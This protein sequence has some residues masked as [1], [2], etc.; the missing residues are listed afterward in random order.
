MD[1]ME[2]R[3]KNLMAALPQDIDVALIQSDINRRYLTGLD[4]SAG[5]LLCFRDEAVLLIDFRYIEIARETVKHC[6]VVEQDRVYAQIVSLFAEHGV[7]NVAIESMQVTLHE[8]SQLKKNITGDWNW[9]CDDTLSRT[10]TEMRMVKSEDEIEKLRKAEQ[11]TELALADIKT[12]A[13]VGMSEREIMLRLNQTMLELGSEGES[14]PTIALVGAATSMPHGVPSAQ[15]YLKDGDFVLLDF[16]AIFEGYHSDTTRTFCVGD[17]SAKMRAVYDIVLK[18]QE[19]ALA[20]ARS[21]ITG[22]Q[23]D[24]AARK[25]I[26]D[27]GYGDAFGHSL[28]HGV[29]LEIHEQPNASPRSNV[30]LKQGHVVTIEPGIYLAGEFGVRTE[31]MI[32]IR[33]GGYENLTASSK[34][35]KV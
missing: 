9:T 35:I 25:V 2:M 27:A 30:V 33:D 3:I 15:R 12:Y 14:F 10:I 28:G 13:K 4:S 31:D 1:A 11:I 16:G 21:G 23:L 19:A 34:A 17:P 7:K 26:A 29:G 20:E 32:V 5:I 24:A 22:A 18:A 8:A 6:R